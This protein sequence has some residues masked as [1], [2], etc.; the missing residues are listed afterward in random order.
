MKL[1]INELKP[2]QDNPRVIKDFKFKK[3]VQSIKEFPEMLEL[4][5]IVVDEDMTILGGNMR[6]RA[7]IE[8]GVKEIPVKV[9]KNLSEDQK[10][11]FIVKDNLSFGEWDWDMLGNSFDF[12]MLDDWAL[13]LP[14]S[15]FKEDIDYSILDD[16]D[17]EKELDG[18]EGSVRR[19]LQIPFES[20]NYEEAKE[21]YKFWVD[22]GAYVGGMIMEFLKSEKEKI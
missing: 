17:F 16:E 8:A 22:S 12:E 14:S 21:L 3:L 20:D 1:K 10:K 13:E 6:Y 18:M 15:M 19:A 9:A 5:P 11:E 7:C 2:N 4:R